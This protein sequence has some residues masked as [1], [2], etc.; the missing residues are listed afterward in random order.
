M[1]KKGTR[2]T[3][4]FPELNDMEQ[5]IWDLLKHHSVLEIDH[6]SILAQQSSSKLASILLNLELKGLVNALPGKR[7]QARPFKNP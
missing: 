4:L 7:Y 2:Q 1:S 5:R 6:L 3:V